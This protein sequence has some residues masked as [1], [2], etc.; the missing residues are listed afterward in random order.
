MTGQS[1]N[2]TERSKG[3]AFV[4]S[5]LAESDDLDAS[6][7]L[8]YLLGLIGEA[9]KYHRDFESD[10]ERAQWVV[11]QWC[12]ETGYH[13]DLTEYPTGQTVPRGTT[14]PRLDGY[15]RTLLE[16]ESDD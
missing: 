4:R 6:N 3:D 10:K 16:G 8:E 14:P 2:E 5:L 1:A 7:D 12:Q 13:P 9:I 11:A 15:Q